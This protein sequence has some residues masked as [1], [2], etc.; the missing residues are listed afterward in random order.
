MSVEIPRP[1]YG[2]LT[3]NVVAADANDRPRDGGMVSQGLK[4]KEKII[5]YK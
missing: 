3:E 2:V 1:P 4:P 5:S